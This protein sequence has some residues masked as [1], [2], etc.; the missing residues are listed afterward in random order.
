[1]S[2]VHS[3]WDRLLA[4]LSHSESLSGVRTLSRRPERQGQIPKV[5]AGEG[6]FSQ[7]SKQLL[8]IE[9]LGVTTLEGRKGTPTNPR[10]FH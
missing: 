2:P 5:P 10:R 9:A 4:D 8:L 1:M 6:N 7:Y 3:N